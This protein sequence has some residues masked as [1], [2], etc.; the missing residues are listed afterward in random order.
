MKVAV[1]NDHRGV[2]VKLRVVGLLTELGHEV[3]DLGATGPTGVDYPDYAIPVAEEVSTG[4][5]DRGVLICATGH[6]MCIAANKVCGVRAVNCRDVIDAELSR[7]HN[8]SN[9]VCVA[10][11]LLGEDQIER[12]VRAWLVTDFEGG[13]HTRRREKVTAYEKA[14][15][16]PA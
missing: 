4:K 16:P 12:M 5:A 1:G 6:G 15:E 11:D 2:N 10:A 9:V 14:H 7:R 13:R 8:D 3:H